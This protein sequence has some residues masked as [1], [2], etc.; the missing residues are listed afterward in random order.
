MWK[1]LYRQRY[2][3]LAAITLVAVVAYSWSY[4]QWRQKVVYVDKSSTTTDA[5]GN[6]Y[7]NGVQVYPDPNRW[8]YLPAIQVY[9]G[10]QAAR[11]LA[12]PDPAWPYSISL[13]FSEDQAEPGI[14]AIH[15]F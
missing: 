3:L 9:K 15:H 8:F 7:E 5:A 12:N 11:N 10:Y 6:V 4:N 14:I 1:A 13:S 2:W